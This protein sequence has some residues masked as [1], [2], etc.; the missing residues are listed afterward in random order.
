[1]Q[2]DFTPFTYL[3]SQKLLAQLQSAY[4]FAAFSVFGRTV[5]KRG[6]FSLT[7]GEGTDTVLFLAGLEAEDTAASLLLYRFFARLCAAY[8]TDG[9]LCNVQIRRSLQGRKITIV[10][11]VS[12]DAFEIRRYGALGAGCYAGLVSRAA[13]NTFASWRANARGVN[14]AHNF[15]FHH[16]SVLLDTAAANPSPFAYAGP[17]PE[18]ET[19]TQAVVRLCLREDFRHS[20]ILAGFGRHLFWSGAEGCFEKNEIPLT[21]KVLAGAADYTLSEKE[22]TLRHGAFSEWF[23]TEFHRPAFTVA[24]GNYPQ[25]QNQAEFDEV[26]REIEEMLVLSAIL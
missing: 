21:A 4:P 26:Y 3:Q 7:L 2:I 25:I 22:E 12:P 19:E 20:V 10:P 14:I 17:A 1:M 16:Q 15:D 9:S 13:G 11:C 5:A 18:S 24:A 8:H 23:S 6:I